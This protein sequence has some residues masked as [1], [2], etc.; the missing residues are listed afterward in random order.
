MRTTSTKSFTIVLVL[1]ALLAAPAFAAP[2]DPRHQPRTPGDQGQTPI[3]RLIQQI[4]HLVHVSD[5]LIVPQP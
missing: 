4:K 1:T 3:Q 2:D 5:I